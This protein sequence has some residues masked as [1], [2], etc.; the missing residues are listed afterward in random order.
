MS[1]LE[2]CNEYETLNLGSTLNA[3]MVLQHEN[4]K[5]MFALHNM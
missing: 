5:C 1:K 3:E 4:L 2:Y